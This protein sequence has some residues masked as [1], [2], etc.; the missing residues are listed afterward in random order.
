[1]DV[2]LAFDWDAENT[3]HLSRHGVTPG[4]F[5]QLMCGDPIY[6]EYQTANGEERYKVLGATGSGVTLIA[7]WT[8]R[9][10]KVRAV[11][12][13]RAGRAHQERYWRARS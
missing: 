13:Y 10:G 9:E 11:T 1:M 4:E 7:I 8:P 12:A 5:E 3:R 6:L 2:S